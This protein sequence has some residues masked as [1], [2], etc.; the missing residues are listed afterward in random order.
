MPYH[1]YSFDIFFSA[2]LVNL[3]L[4]EV[5]PRVVETLGIH[6]ALF[7]YCCQSRYNSNQILGYISR[8]SLRNC[9]NCTSFHSVFLGCYVWRAPVSDIRDFKI[10]HYGRLG[11]LDR[12]NV[13][14]NTRDLL[15]LSFWDS[16]FSPGSSSCQKNTSFLAPIRSQNGGLELVW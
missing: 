15:S 6:I 7:K 9:E 1:D 5:L 10:G 3:N 8:N 12:C 4:S 16:M 2:V 11:Q 13:T 14:Q